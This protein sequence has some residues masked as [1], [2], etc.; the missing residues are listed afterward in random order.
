MHW[1]VT[2]AR[3]D[4]AACEADWAGVIAQ[5]QAAG[6]RPS[7]AYN[8]GAC[9]HGVRMPGRTWAIR[10]AANGTSQANADYWAVVALNAPGD[11]PTPALLTTLAG[12]ID[13]APDLDSRDVRPHSDFFATACCG[14]E[15]RAW[16]AQGAV[17][18]S[19]PSPTVEDRMKPGL[20]VDAA[21]A[22]YVYDPNNHTANHIGNPDALSAIQSLRQLE[23][24]STAI[25]RNGTTDALL[26]DANKLDVPPGGPVAIDLSG[27]TVSGT[28]TGSAV[29]DG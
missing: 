22:V 12:L 19:Q 29:A 5:H 2:P 14:D 4:H 1:T 21:G 18:P 10:S 9:P 24:L 25:V 8:W 3:D 7:P 6:Y 11:V 28:F 27:F 23:G 13:E 15:L 20:F 26:A 17:A 16:V